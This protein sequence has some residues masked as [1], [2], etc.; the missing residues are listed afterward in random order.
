[1][2]TPC[3]SDPEMWTAEMASS[4][5]EAATL[6]R[7][8]HRITECGAEAMRAGKVHGVWGGVDFSRPGPRKEAS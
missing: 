1:M 3:Q 6:C 5:A 7:G 8:C 4:R 2:K